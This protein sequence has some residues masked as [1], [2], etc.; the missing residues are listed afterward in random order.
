M[1]VCQVFATIFCLILAVALFLPAARADDW[2]QMTKLSFSE[3][4]E[5]PGAVLPAGTYWFV[6]LDNPSER[7]LVQIFSSDWSQ[8]YATVITI[9]TYR[10][11]PTDKTEIKVAERPRQDPVALL[12][13][14]YP[15]LLTGHEFLYPRKEEARLAREAKM[16]ILAQPMNVASNFAPGA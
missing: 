11:E 9:P 6:L 5:I 3:P 4:I 10:Q 2:N 14:Y 7:N 12:N 15:G 1:N 8:L 16:D 13:W